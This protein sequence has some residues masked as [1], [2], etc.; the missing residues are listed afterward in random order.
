MLSLKKIKFLIEKGVCKLNGQIET[1]AS[2]K[3][4]KDDQVILKKAWDK[5]KT[6]PK[7]IKPKILYEDE[8]FFAINKPTQMLCT[9]DY[10]QKLFN[11]RCFLIHRLDKETSGVLLIA[12]SLEVKNKF[13]TLFKQKKVNKIYIA[14]ADGDFRKKKN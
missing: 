1:F 5:G 12:K 8:F 6:L 7:E 3:L 4:N 10:F 9:D 11:K 2:T 13:I 14:V